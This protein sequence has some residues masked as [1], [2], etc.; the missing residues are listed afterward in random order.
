RILKDVVLGM[1]DHEQFAGLPVADFPRRLTL[2][3][4]LKL[5]GLKVAGNCTST[6]LRI[7]LLKRRAAR[8]RI[9]PFAV[10]IMNFEFQFSGGWIEFLHGVLAGFRTVHRPA[11]IAVDV[12]V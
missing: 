2:R 1:I 9:L 11:G 4:I 3:G 12:P 5:A 6:G 7:E 8:S 10:F